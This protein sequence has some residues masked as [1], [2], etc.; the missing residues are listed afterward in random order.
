MSY[1]EKMKERRIEERKPYKTAVRKLLNQPRVDNKR[2]NG[3][4]L[5]KKGT[6]YI[7]EGTIG[8][9]PF[10]STMIGH[11]NMDGY[12]PSTRLYNMSTLLDREFQYDIGLPS[13]EVLVNYWALFVTAYNLETK[14]NR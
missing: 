5:I 13:K 2:L 12:I 6:E 8:G 14:R 1:A 9:G 11:L 10:I 3:S 4:L 7:Q